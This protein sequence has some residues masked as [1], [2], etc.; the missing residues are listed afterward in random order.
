MTE[1]EKINLLIESRQSA[2]NYLALRLMIDVLHLS[3][4]EA[5]L[6]LKLG[7]TSLKTCT[8]EI[9]DIKVCYE[10]D[11]HQ[12]IDVPSDW[13]YIRRRVFFREQELTEYF[14]ETY[15]EEVYWFNADFDILKEVVE[16]KNDFPYLV[17]IVESLFNCL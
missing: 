16:I 1:Q 17:P 11:F 9:A 6:K 14:E 3:F 5:F 12:M 15:V 2:N 13:V 8:L 10:V 4:E 7:K